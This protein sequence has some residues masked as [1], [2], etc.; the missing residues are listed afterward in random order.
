MS[1]GDVIKIRVCHVLLGLLIALWLS[2]VAVMLTAILDGSVELWRV[3][4]LIAWIAAPSTIAVATW[5]RN[6]AIAAAFEVGLRAGQ[7]YPDGGVSHLPRTRD[8]T[9]GHR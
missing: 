2:V 5:R 7:M 4:S 9:G 3:G 6:A 8:F 1:Y